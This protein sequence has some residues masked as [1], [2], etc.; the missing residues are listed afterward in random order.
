MR[1]QRR[2]NSRF[3]AFGLGALT[4]ITGC[5]V[6]LDLKDP[7]TLDSIVVVEFD[8]TH[9]IP[10]LQT[11]PI[12]TGLAQFEG[13]PG[14]SAR[15]QK[16]QLGTATQCSAF[17]SGW[18][19]NQPIVIYLSNEI[20]MTTVTAGVKVIAQKGLLPTPVTYTATI[21]KRPPPDPRCTEAGT[22]GARP[23]DPMLTELRAARQ[24]LGL[25]V[26]ADANVKLDCMPEG[27]IGNFQEAYGPDDV[28]TGYQLVL[29]PEGG[30]FDADTNYV[31]L[32]ESW[33][34]PDGTPH[35]LRA[36]DGS[37]VWGSSLFSSLNVPEE[38]KP[39]DI[40]GVISSP[41]VRSNLQGQVIANYCG[42]SIIADNPVPAVAFGDLSTTDKRVVD[43]VAS[44]RARA[45][46]PLL[47]EYFSR[48]I[49]P[50]VLAG[51][52][53]RSKL[54]FANAW[55]T[56]VYGSIEFD[57]AKGAFPF[58]NN[59]LM[60]ATTGPGL[61]D[62]RV[63]L[64][65]VPCDMSGQPAGCD[66]P[67]AAALKGGLNTLEGFSTTAPII[68]NTTKNVNPAT[69]MDDQGNSR[70]VMYPLN[71]QG[72]IDGDAVE[73]TVEVIEATDIAKA[74]IRITPVA[75][76]AQKT[77]YVVGYK[78]GIED[79]SGHVLL[80]G[81]T[82]NF[83]KLPVPLLAADGGLNPGLANVD[84]DLI[85]FIPGPKPQ[86]E[87]FSVDVAVQQSLECSTIPTAGRLATELEVK[88]T[89]AAVELQLMRARWQV[90]FEALEGATPEVKRDDVLMAFTLK[91][92]D[93]TGALDLTRGAL[94]DVWD[95]IAEMAGRPRLIGPLPN[96]QTGTPPFV[97]GPQQWE[98]L[99]GVAKTYCVPACQAGA[100]QPNPPAMCTDA[101]GEPTDEV[102]RH[103]VCLLITDL[104]V[105]ALGRGD[106]Y[107]MRTPKITKGSPYTAGTFNPVHFDPRHPAFQPP[108]FQ[109]LP[110]WVITPTGTSSA[111]PVPVAIFQHGLGRAKEDGFAL[112]N[113]YAREGLATVL[114]DLPFHGSRASD[115]ARVV[116]DAMGNASTLPCAD[117]DPAD[118]V[119]DPTTNACQICDDM[120][121]NCMDA[122]DG[123]RDPSATGFLSTNLFA[124]R[125]N[126][127]QAV[128]DHL[129]L[130]RTLQREGNAVG[131]LPQLNG[132]SV[133]YSGQSFG[134]ITGG[135]FAAFAPELTAAVLNVGG[136]GLI[137]N[138]LLNSVPSINGPLFAGLAAAG[139]CTPANPA[140]PSEGCADD[141]GFRQF[142]QTAQW[143]IDPGDPLANSIAVDAPHNML[144]PLG[145]DKVLLQMAIPDPVVPNL[146]TLALGRA[147]GFDT[148]NRGM[149][150]PFQVW[151]FGASA[152]ATGCH[153][154]LLDTVC[155]GSIIENICA[156]FGA[157][158]Q[159]A[160]FIA[161]G[162]ME[163][164]KRS[165]DIVTPAGPLQ[166][167]NF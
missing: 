112:A 4:A 101:M 76:L 120:G 14:L 64:P 35:G 143:V 52:T 22:N 144:P 153:G 133:G 59:Q 58:P 23:A 43:G 56:D 68:V 86:I 37:R 38:A 66:T 126:F 2:V 71:D 50:V 13:A 91:T 74:A 11:I 51:L 80:P 163:I 48:V 97:D 131:R 47:Y 136:G 125:D 39:V 87:Q 34:D 128:I 62:L 45:G 3:F 94:L 77:T 75:P 17:A 93:I 113:T 164:K 124:G 55:T 15:A 32:V 162:A 16:C 145:T 27:S 154:F 152:A 31:L 132:M 114:M 19:L 82:F 89:A 30:A 158:Q 69:M 157:Q 26:D 54:V 108:P 12:P 63:N 100:L 9:P 53:E 167:P 139:I 165:A 147:Y 138:I 119:C 72:V 18:P 65:I 159:A 122:C 156:T 111:A 149:G 49:N 118:V 46:L 8:P 5:P 6:E 146:S 117:V 140:N 57:P 41:L 95:G 116:M 92:Q 40:D 161:S 21:S 129:T 148:S 42:V 24:A 78:R 142:L 61:N 127:R 1:D 110:V 160:R 105:G 134:G 109:D 166:C 85:S 106:L 99:I 36:K 83:L 135:N 88:G 10:V 137:N 90:A 67:S 102:R 130:L 121:M 151:D 96:P 7:V 60:T 28:P 155:G 84:K 44:L 115:I 103:G 33:D 81:S 98:A 73:L 79:T 123:Q 141:D 70:V 150:S 25:P 104:A 20:D 107:L 29:F